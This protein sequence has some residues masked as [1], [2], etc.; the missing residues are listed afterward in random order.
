MVTSNMTR[1]DGVLDRMYIGQQQEQQQQ[2]HPQQSFVSLPD[3]PGISGL[4][5]HSKENNDYVV[6]SMNHHHHHQSHS[7]HQG[8]AARGVSATPLLQSS[9]SPSPSSQAT[10]HG[11]I[12]MN[13]MTIHQHQHHH[14]HQQQGGLMS[15]SIASTRKTTT[16]QLIQLHNPNDFNMG[17]YTISPSTTPSGI[18]FNNSSVQPLPPSHSH[19]S[20]SEHQHQ[21]QQQ[22]Q[23]QQRTL[24]HYQD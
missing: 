6:M 4:P 3:T 23:E 15:P 10:I 14:H 11:S 20:I 9:S 17:K 8:W 21:Q 12:I 19:S 13:P 24:W 22:Q 2:T 18:L 1:S 16:E 7:Q 5:A